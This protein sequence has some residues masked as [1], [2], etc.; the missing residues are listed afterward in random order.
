LIR[1]AYESGDPFDLAICDC[2]KGRI[3]RAMGEAVI[4]DRLDLHDPAHQ[5]AHRERFEGETQSAPDRG[6]YLSV[7]KTKKAKL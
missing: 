7:G 5:I 6:D 1:V 2:R 3:Y 4:R